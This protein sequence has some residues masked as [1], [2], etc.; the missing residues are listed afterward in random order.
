MDFHW[1]KAPKTQEEEK[2]QFDKLYHLLVQ[3]SHK[4]QQVPATPATPA[5]AFSASASSSSTALTSAVSR[6]SAFPEDE[7]TT[8]KMDILANFSSTDTMTPLQTCKGCDRSFYSTFEMEKHHRQSPACQRCSTIDALPS[9][10]LSFLSFMEKGLSEVMEIDGSHAR[11]RFCQK[12]LPSRK[13][14]EKHFALSLP[15]NRLAYH[16]FHQ[17]YTALSDSKE[18]V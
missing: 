8:L 13:A 4:G 17:W 10:A 5:S 3:L 2:A 9:P 16:A 1:I 11:C 18:K 12:D 7:F 6:A 14:Q 15:C